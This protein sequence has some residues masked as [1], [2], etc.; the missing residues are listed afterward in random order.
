[1]KRKIVNGFILV[2]LLVLINLTAFVL[3]KYFTLKDQEKARTVVGKTQTQPIKKETKL[4]DKEILIKKLNN[5]NKLMVLS[6]ET[7]IQAT[8]SNKV[9]SDDDVNF[10]WIK[11]WIDNANSKDLKVNAIYTYQFHYDLTDFN[12]ALE[13]EGD[14]VNIYLSRNRLECQVELLE[15]KSIYSDRVGLLES[16]FMPQEINSLN[17]RTKDLVL[18]RIQSDKELRDK[19]MINIQKNIQELLGV[20]CKFDVSDSDILEY[21]D[22]IV[23]KIN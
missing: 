17:A 9:V 22:G 7:E 10:R 21:N 3:G 14:A 18:N 12:H 11:D 4:I 19:A 16:S 23:L 1:M 8:Y 15:N 2:L 6:G 5:E 13:V 20:K